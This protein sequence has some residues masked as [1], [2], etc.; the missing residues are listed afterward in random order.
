M[1]IFSYKSKK[2]NKLKSLKCVGIWTQDQWIKSPVLFHWATHFLRFNV[3]AITQEKG[4]RTLDVLFP[5]QISY[6]TAPFPEKESIYRSKR[7]S[8]LHYQICNL[9]HYHYAIQPI[10]NF[11]RLTGIEPVTFRATTWYSTNWA[12]I[13]RIKWNKRI[14]TFVWSYQKRLPCRLA[15]FQTPQERFELST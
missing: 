1:G 11:R 4:I 9:T 2:T 15:M 7:E 6:Q 12:I 8:N 3:K 5:K 14:R 13:A 10:K